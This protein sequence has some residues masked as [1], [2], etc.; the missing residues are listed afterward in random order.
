ETLGPS[1]GL[2]E[3]WDDVAAASA[4][5]RAVADAAVRGRMLEAQRIAL[6]HFSV[7]EARARFV[8]AA[9]FLQTGEESSLFER[10]P[11]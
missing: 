8:A 7:E 11:R 9:R 5:N 3:V 4:I 10:L 1:P 6:R 2:L